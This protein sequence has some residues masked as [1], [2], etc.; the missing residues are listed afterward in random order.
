MF[1]VS[2]KVGFFREPGRVAHSLAPGRLRR[3]VEESALDLGRT[4]DV[5]FL[6]NPEKSL[7]GVSPTHARDRLEAACTVL[8]EAVAA[9]LCASWGISSWDTRPVIQA[10]DDGALAKAPPPD[11]LMVRAGLTVPSDQLDASERTA[12]NLGAPPDRLWG[13]S[14]FGGDAARDVWKRFKAAAFLCPDEKGSNVQAVFRASYELPRVARI[15]VS[16]SNVDHMRELASAEVLKVD[17]DQI[18][19]YR[20]LLRERRPHS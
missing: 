7:V 12:E 17:L 11:I 10:L 19:R 3:A 4:P 16:S 8:N 20:Q 13:M 6:H 18:S 14:P 15:A 2:T 1:S 9:G 5:V